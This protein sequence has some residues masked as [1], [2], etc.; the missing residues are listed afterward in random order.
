MDLLARCWT[1]THLEGEIF[2][3]SI[4]RPELAYHFSILKMK[5]NSVDGKYNE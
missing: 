3:S 1:E 2:L 4:L 5:E